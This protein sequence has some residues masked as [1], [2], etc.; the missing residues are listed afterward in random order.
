MF[1]S[2]ASLAAMHAWAREGVGR[3]GTWVRSLALAR[4][5]ESDARDRP[6]ARARTLVRRSCALVCS[7]ARTCVLQK[8]TL[9]FRYLVTS[10][11]TLMFRY[12]VT[13]L[14]TLIL[15]YP[16]TSL[17][18]LYMSADTFVLTLALDR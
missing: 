16:V 7:R 17:L 11:L 13:S 12:L 4:T 9:I 8:L 15:R 3:W 6:R 18:Y 1:P 14:L 5:H 2:A 10:L